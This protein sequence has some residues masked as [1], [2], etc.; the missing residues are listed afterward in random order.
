MTSSYTLLWPV[1]AFLGSVHLVTLCDIVAAHQQPSLT[2]RVTRSLYRSVV[3]PRL[4]S[5]PSIPL[6]P[7]SSSPSPSI[8]NP[9]AYSKHLQA[10]GE[11]G[12]TWKRAS[13]PED[14]LREA[15]VVSGTAG[16]CRAGHTFTS[17]HGP[18]AVCLEHPAPLP[19]IQVAFTLALR[20]THMHSSSLTRSM[21]AWKTC[22]AAFLFFFYPLDSQ[23]HALLLVQLDA[24]GGNPQYAIT[25]HEQAC[26][27]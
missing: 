13:T 1:F 10:N 20:H 7:A 14:V 22:A 6:L 25:M 18:E 2:M 26:S 15:D 24:V 27:F 3:L 23:R 19:P 21:H 9:S 5:L 4:P 12:V 16:Q 11:P 17:H 8:P